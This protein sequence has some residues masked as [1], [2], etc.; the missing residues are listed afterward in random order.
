M[1]VRLLLI[2]M[3]ITLLAFGVTLAAQTDTGVEVCSNFIQQALETVGNNCGFLDRNSACYGYNTV[4]ASFTQPQPEGFFSAPNERASINTLTTIATSPLRTNLNDWGIALLSIQANLPDTL[5]GQNVVLMLLGDAEIENEVD[6]ENA[7]VPGE[8][9]VVTAAAGGNLY[10]QPRVDAD[11]VGFVP[12]NTNLQADAISSDGG[13]VRVVYQGLP[14]WIAVGTLAGG[15]D[16]SGLGIVGPETRTTGQAFYLRTNIGQTDCVEA[17]DS[18]IVQGPQNI[19]VDISTNGA[20]IRLGSTIVL[21]VIEI[22]PD[23]ARALQE[24]FGFT[25]PI[26]AL[27]EVTTLD[28]EAILNPD[29]DDEQVVPAGSRAFRCLAEPADIALAGDPNDAKV[30]GGCPWFGFEDLPPEVLRAQF[31]GFEGIV[32]NYEIEL[33]DGEPTPVN[34]LRPVTGGFITNTPLPTLTPTSVPFPTNTQV[35]PA[36]TSTFTF[37]PTETS[38]ATFTNT[39]TFTPTATDTATNTATATETATNTSTATETATF[40]A[41]STETFTATATATATSVFTSTPT[42]TA[43]FTATATDTSVFTSTPTETATFT[44]TATETFTATAT[45]TFTATATETFTATATETFTP[46]PTETPVDACGA[47]IPNPITTMEELICSIELANDEITHP[48][49]DTLNLAPSG[50]FAA[51]GPYDGSGETALPLITTDIAIAGN[52]STIY[53]GKITP[54]PL[55]FIEVGTTGVLTMSNLEF[56]NGAA[57]SPGGAILSQGSMHLDNVDFSGN[58]APDGLGGA[59]YQEGGGRTLEIVN[60][61]FTFN[62]ASDGGGAIAINRG[63]LTITNSSLTDNDTDGNGG[64]IHV[65]GSTTNV[66]IDGSDISFNRALSGDGGGIYFSPSE[67]DLT[68]QHSTVNGNPAVNGGGIWADNNVTID[69]TTVDGNSASNQGGSL[70]IC[71]FMTNIAFSTVSRGTSSESIGGI[72]GC[73]GSEISLLNSTVS[74]NAGGGILTLGEVFVDFTTVTD[75]DGVGV[76]TAGTNSYLK[77]SIIAGNS[78]AQCSGSFFTSDVNFDTDDT[79][80]DATTATITELALDPTLQNNGGETETHAL[81]D[82][83]VAIS[84]VT[85]CAVLFGEGDLLTTDQRDLPRP[86][87]GGTDCDAGSYENQITVGPGD[88]VTIP[89]PVTTVDEFIC[90]I[91]LANDEVGHPGQDTINLLD[92]ATY[93]FPGPGDDYPNALPVITSDILINGS[94]ST[95]DWTGGETELR[96][97]EVAPSGTLTLNSLRAFDGQVTGGNYGGVVSSQGTLNLNSVTFGD[98]DAPRGGAIYQLGGTLNVFN[99]DLG[100]SMAFSGT[101]YG[102]AIYAVDATIIVTSSTFTG[103]DA[104]NGGAIYAEGTTQLSVINSTFDTNNVAGSGGAIY[105]CTTTTGFTAIEAS[106]LSN[107]SATTGGGFHNCA[108]DDSSMLNTTLSGNT[109]TAIESEGALSLA[110]VTVGYNF[111]GA[112]TGAG[113]QAIK[114]T[115]LTGNNATECTGS[116]PVASGMNFV[117]DA[118]CGSGSNVTVATT[119]A[120]GVNST[121]AD[122]GGPTHTHELFDSSVAISTATDCTNFT[123]LTIVVDQRGEPRPAPSGTNCDPGAYE[124][125]TSTGDTCTTIAN[126]ITNNDE[127]ICA[128]ELAN[129]ETNFPGQDTLNLASGG[130]FDF[131][132]TYDALN[133]VPPITSDIVINGNGATLHRLGGEFYLRFFQVTVDGALTLDNLTLD[134]ADLNADYGAGV[135]SEGILTITDSTLTGNSA[136]L[137]GAIYQSGNTLSI[138]GSSFSFNSA[139][140][141]IGYGGAILLTNTTATIG[142]TTFDNNIAV[143]GGAVAALGSTFLDLDGGSF[144][145]NSA[146]TDGGGV[147]FGDT[148]DGEIV[149]VTFDGNSSDSTG[150][151]V[152]NISSGTVL[153]QNATLDNNTADGAGGAVYT[154]NGFVQV[155]STGMDTNSASNGGAIAIDGTGAASLTMN[156]STLSNNTATTNGGG[157]YFGAEG[158]TLTVVGT[159]ITDNDANQG[160]GVYSVSASGSYNITYTSVVGNDA[161]GVGGGLYLATTSGGGYVEHAVIEGNTAGT[162]GGGIYTC[163]PVIVPSI[164]L[165][166]VSSNTAPAAG[167][168]DACGSDLTSLV[169]DTLSGN[170]GGGIRSAGSVNASFVTVV[171]NTGNGLSGSGTVNLKNSIVAGNSLAECAVTTL[172]LSGV[173]F[174]DDASCGAATAV[175]AAQLA[176]NSTLTNNGG[177]TK[178]HALGDSSVA[179]STATDCTTVTGGGVSVDQRDMTRP[180]PTGTN[181][182]PGAY[183]NQTATPFTGCAPAIPDPITTIDEFICAIELANDEVNYPGLNTLHIEPDTTFM[184]TAPYESTGNALPVITSAIDIYNL[185]HLTRDADAPS[186]RFFEVSSTGDLLTF[187]LQFNGG[188]APAGTNGGAFL[189]AGI[190]DVVDGELNGNSAP[191]GSGGAIYHTGS[192]LGFGNNNVLNNFASGQGGAIYTAS[193]VDAVL[194]GMIF[195]GNTSGGNGGAIYN[196]GQ[197]SMSGVSVISNTTGLSGSVYSC[198]TTAATRSTIANTTG[199]IPHG[200]VGCAADKLT[201]IN[202]TVSGNTA[203]GIVSQGSVEIAFTTIANNGVAGIVRSGSGTNAAESSIF[204]S[205][206]TNCSPVLNTNNGANLSSD[207]SCGVPF[208]PAASFELGALQPPHPLVHPI[209]DTSVAINTGDC[210]SFLGTVD[211]DAIGQTRP[212]FT[213]CDSGSFEN[214]NSDGGGSGGIAGADL[215]GTPT[216]TPAPTIE[217]SPTETPTA[218]ATLVEPT[219]TETPI[220]P[221][222]TPTEIV[223]ETPTE[224]PIIDITATPTET[225]AVP[226]PEETPP[227]EVT[228]EATGVAM[229]RALNYVAWFRG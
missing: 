117:D 142:T 169:N 85:D 182:D 158:G 163:M 13:F 112:L 122:N 221:T 209:G 218:E 208:S 94:G 211:V 168:I 1:R 79:C 49:Q 150:G 67:G 43:T 217:A 186:F 126:P 2:P 104:E 207:D 72:Y 69:H 136:T 15:V 127:L 107:N 177:P 86:A 44:A 215:T 165:S 185:A 25:E 135:Y 184:F 222:L 36:P 105:S 9:I 39:A 18:L 151:A 97:F 73:A 106:T 31:G 214:Q 225:L 152:T 76:S 226:P 45:E 140:F 54:P 125:Q 114:N 88:C 212:A 90:A 198:G 229:G 200:Y 102:G 120:I 80:S 96:Y 33:P 77:A 162:S 205:N 154:T 228:P 172:N 66:N 21:R 60:S 192:H 148:S 68:I 5:P 12:E 227:V 41:T 210:A 194:N 178:T 58:N 40:T 171:Y 38:T 82:T 51:E 123:G 119:A 147:I 175:T 189:S 143:Y 46:T 19:H 98:N 100:N 153:F 197:M 219:L 47:G 70:Y 206:G 6:S 166:S 160:A 42:E 179:I 118:S 108:T 65:T 155:F 24:R 89:N 64:A 202:S 7:Y 146:F 115:I 201:M 220:E 188:R 50:L 137:G 196:A 161:V 133:A 37:T 32:L 48:G 103:N 164:I 187:S 130:V 113:T 213:L 14:G 62:N 121:L 10:Y 27:L 116:I 83:S 23:Q 34:T 8:I 91:E 167:G 26:Y 223:G 159:A 81:G 17:P 111:G 128:I 20:D 144:T 183:E 28:G 110:F 156:A 216:S 134:G 224:T 63:T 99:S 71:D 53:R 138:T 204:V 61:T 16:L 129:D 59:I 199:E 52:N 191:S 75:N 195:Q 124:N 180:A 93:T 29:T 22:S 174:A 101:G 78:G 203:S 56:I 139:D 3:I 190:L 74:G 176:L 131:A 109:G 132:T 157:V 193:T 84:T 149:G 55:R 145:S 181:C 95:L 35:V 141:S 87:P 170:S 57:G 30:I 92:G 4:L 173:N 11:L